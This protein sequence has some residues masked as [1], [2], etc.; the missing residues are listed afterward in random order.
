MGSTTARG[1]GREHQ[2]LRREW[3]P[4]VD[5]GQAYCHA[6]R[7]LHGERWIQPGAAWDLGHTPDRTAWTGPEHPLCNRSDGGRRRGLRVPMMTRWEL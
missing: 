6:V 3:S 5:S 1:Y 4:I 2:R 7:C